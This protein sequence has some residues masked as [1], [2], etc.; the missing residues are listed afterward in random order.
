MAQVLTTDPAV[1]APLGM[2]LPWTESPFFE[3]HLE[4]SSLDPAMADM[5]A[6]FARDGFLVFDPQ[7]E[8]LDLLSEKLIGDLGPRYGQ[9]GRIQDAW[10]FSPQVRALAVAPRVL[11]L[12]RVLY[13]REPI[14]FQTLNFPRGTQ[15]A[16]HSDCI[17]F[18][19]V[20]ER[21]MC[22]VWIALEDIDADNGPLHYYPGSHRL[23]VYDMHDLGLFG[24]QIHH[25][26]TLY[27]RYEEFVADMVEALGLTRRE[28]YI[29]KGQAMIWA[30][31]LL[32]GGSPIRDP[33]RSRHSQ[34]THYYFSGCMYYTPLFSDPFIGKTEFRRISDIRTGQVV[35]QYY[36]G[37]QVNMGQ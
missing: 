25:H 35:P 8:H 3:R 37:N 4:Q 34:V 1:K 7:I 20:P 26:K 11:Q 33:G 14:P 32:H 21:F 24:S 6:R 16:T 2:N 10:T 9:K 28:L 29:R 17:H 5:A 31:N 23:P 15:Q 30:A 22:G 36:L 18:S 12:L 13:D 19:S 27:R